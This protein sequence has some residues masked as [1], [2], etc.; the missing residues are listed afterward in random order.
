MTKHDEFV[1]RRD[2]LNAARGILV[3]LPI[4]GVIWGVI[5]WLVYR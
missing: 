4:A 2:G 5:L 1:S 3:A